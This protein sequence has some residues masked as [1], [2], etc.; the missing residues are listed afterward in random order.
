MADTEKRK[1]Q[2]EA[3][4]L[5]ALGS[6]FEKPYIQELRNFLLEEKRRGAKVYPP[7]PLIFNAFNQTPFSETKVVILGQDPYHGPRQAHGLCFSVQRGIQP[8]PSL[9]NIFKELHDSLG[10]PPAR[11]GDLTHWAKQGVLLL[12]TTL[13]VRAHQPKS[14]AGK[15]WETFT[16]RVI[17]TLNEKRQGLA[18]MLWGGHAKQKAKRID[19]HRHL[20]LAAAHPSPL[21]AHA[22][23][24]GC[25]H[26]AKANAHLEKNG[27]QPVDWA[28][29]D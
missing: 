10:I 23:F 7:G 8:P 5:E 6:E 16:D 12:N 27:M 18:F 24:F 13:T 22:G 4:W 2:I 14:H 9:V 26:F 21:S 3:S 11:H 19:G 25:G 29:P 28:L 20:L 17:D 15:G 1:P